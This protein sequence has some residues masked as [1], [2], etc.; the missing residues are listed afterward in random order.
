MFGASSPIDQ[1]IKSLQAHL[2]SENPIL[3]DVVKSFRQLDR[4][5]V[6]IGDG[7][8]LDAAKLQFTR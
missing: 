4:I 3:L 1:R 8:G 6:G 5:V 2:E 7:K